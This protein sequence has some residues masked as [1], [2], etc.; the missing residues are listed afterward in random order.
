MLKS[1]AT[2]TIG[3][4]DITRALAVL[5]SVRSDT[6]V[7]ALEDALKAVIKL[8]E[9]GAIESAAALGTLLIAPGPLHN[10]SEAYKWLH[11][12]L[13]H[14]GYLTAYKNEY[15]AQGNTY[16]GPIGDFRNEDEVSMCINELGLAVL[17]LLDAQAQ[18]WL[19]EYP[20]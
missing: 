15:E 16:L 12:G 10:A 13:C 6:P 4:S 7:Y 11:I 1:P 18:A 17:P 2:H 5:E 20:L 3:S 14:Q 19:V 9:A 8:I